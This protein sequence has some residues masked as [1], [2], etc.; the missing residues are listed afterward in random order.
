MKKNFIYPLLLSSLAASYSANIS[1]KLLP[2]AD[3]AEFVPNQLVAKLKPAPYVSKFELENLGVSIEMLKAS[4][5]YAVI[6]VTDKTANL[7]Q[8]I[9]QLMDSG[10]YEYVEKN[11][12][13]HSTV[14]PVDTNL[15]NQWYIN[16]NGL[17]GADLNMFAAWDIQNTAS[18]SL[19]AVIDDGFDLSHPD[20]VNSYINDGRC[21]A[22]EA[23]YCGG[24]TDAGYTAD[25]QTHGTWVV[26]TFAATANNARGIAGASWDVMLL[27][28]KVD[29]TS[30]AIIQAVD[31]AIA[32]NVSIINM[33]F[34]G[35]GF[36]QAQFDA[37]TRAMNAGILL[38]SSA[39]NGDMSN[40]KGQIV[41]PANYDLPNMISVAATDNLDRITNWSQWGPLTVD[42]A[43]PGQS[44]FTTS[45][46]STYQ[47]VSGTS[48]SSPLVSGIAAL[49][50]ENTGAT[51]YKQL[52]AHLLNG[53]EASVS[54]QNKSS[55]N[56]MTATG[57]LDAV[58]ALT[59]PSTG[60]ITVSAIRVDDSVSG[61]DNGIFDPGETVNL[62]VELTNIW[63]TENNI[64]AN[65][66]T[67]SSIFTVNN[68]QANL[69]S[70]SQDATAEVSFQVTASDFLGN[71][72]E[73]F[74]LDLTTDNGALTTRNFYY[75]I[76]KINLNE[77]HSQAFQRWFWD[78][79]HA[80]TVN[81]P[82][83]ATNLEI[84]TTS[85][86]AIDIDLIAAFGAPPVY[87]IT[88]DP[89]EGEGFFVVDRTDP[90][91]FVSGNQ[92]GNENISIPNP[93]EGVY[94]IV[95][96]NFDQVNHVYTITANLAAPAPG[97]FEISP[98]AIT[99]D[100]TDST[101]TI[102][103]ERNG[104]VGP[105]SVD[106]ATSDVTAV[107]GSDYTTNAGTLSWADGDNTAKTITVSI[108]DDNVEESSETFTV[109]L[110]NATGGATIG[111]NA[112]AT[113]TI[114]DDDSPG[115]L[116]FSAS[117]VNVNETTANVTVTVTR[118]GGTN[119]AASVDIA[120]A[121]GSATAGSDYEATSDQ[122]N[123][124]DGEDGS[125]T[126]TINIIDDTVDESN[127]TISVTLSNAQ[128]STLDSPASMTVTIVDN[129]A[130]PTPPP[131][132]GGGGGGGSMG[133]L[134]SLVLLLRLRK[135]KAV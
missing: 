1:A 89:P 31:E 91:V 80:Y 28:L 79:Y 127:E 78:E 36:S 95:V 130:A 53:G 76:S 107:A 73:L 63:S 99:V 51:D 58:K 34:G 56:G 131:S 22:S 135:R 66:S 102:T 60:V 21:F 10:L 16:N 87:N 27:P 32:Q 49:I 132:N 44:I 57:R 134:I 30:S 121:D 93:K 67:G 65:L 88:L 4:D 50:K 104:T 109:A 25:D 70:L 13:Y 119:G 52:K 3:N 6:N 18:N 85:N 86:N 92:D 47:S 96:V 72:S 29:L 35:P 37:Y 90:D 100:E 55:F 7:G 125:K 8:K 15:P 64:V 9:I 45:V 133:W 11:Y 54:S 124:A 20:L 81:V 77:T 105:V 74:S 115:T 84:I 128:G 5:D 82:A 129:D 106:Y 38:V 12:R 101:A 98:N 112:S 113:V 123:W 71:E 43:A 17:S 120:T 68:P 48:F 61:N 2:Q 83:G 94:H 40:D 108:L 114:N 116:Q 103:V 117:S 26:G 46:N 33:S 126:F 23:S 110:N 42:I 39:G 122:L 75:E 69:A 97:S 41:Y 118:A 24:N 19:V 111:T 59:A 62:I 14:T